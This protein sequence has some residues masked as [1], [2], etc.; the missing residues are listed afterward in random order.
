MKFIKNN[1]IYVQQKDLFSVSEFIA[2]PNY[3]WNEVFKNKT[4]FY[5]EDDEKYI[6]FKNEESIIFFKDI[7][8]IIDINWLISL[9]EEQ[10]ENEIEKCNNILNKL[11][12]EWLKLSIYERKNIY[13]YK[14]NDL[15]EEKIKYKKENL[16][17]YKNNT[18]NRVKRL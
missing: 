6:E 10:I 4:I 12:K 7:D 9:T 2:F 18:Y 1:K 8:C 15:I 11:A 5:G 14:T 13:D 17:E 16:M 3:I